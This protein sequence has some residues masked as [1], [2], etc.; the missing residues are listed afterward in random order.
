MRKNELI[1]LLFAIEGNPEITLWNGFVGDW[2]PINNKL[3]EIELVKENPQHIRDAIN[4]E[5][6]R[7]GLPPITDDEM[8]K[9][10]K[11]HYSKWEM[12]NEFVTEDEMFRWYGT[13]RKKIIVLQA[14]LRG[15]STWDRAGDMSY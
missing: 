2:M 8:A 5:H 12:P 14:K 13:K 15:K 1:N 7:D 10:I 3:G 11:E 9:V 6:H 4:W